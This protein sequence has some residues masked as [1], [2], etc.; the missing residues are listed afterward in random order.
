MPGF[1]DQ[2]IFARKKRLRMEIGGAILSFKLN[3][4]G[5]ITRCRVEF[6]LFFDRGYYRPF[7]ESDAKIL[8]GHLVI[9]Q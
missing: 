2:T 6:N 7:L 9:Q 3:P 1:Q 8:K 5:A 4:E